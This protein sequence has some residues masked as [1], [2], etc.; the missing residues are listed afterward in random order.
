MKSV[1]IGFS[2]PS[3]FKI[4]AEVIK[5]YM[6]TSYSHVYLKIKSK[7]YNSGIIFQASHGKVHCVCEPHFRSEN[8]I[9]AEFKYEIESAKYKELYTYCIEALQKPYGYLGIIKLAFHKLFKR[10]DGARTFHCSEL[11]ARALPS[12][13]IKDP[14]YI[15]PE[16]L[17]EYL[18]FKKEIKRV[19]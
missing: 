10:G 17:Y 19:I 3:E 11:A 8:E 18:Q 16:D 6:G 9:I 7:W 14:D 12:L 4:G 2:R 13:A 1:I 5:L 15:T